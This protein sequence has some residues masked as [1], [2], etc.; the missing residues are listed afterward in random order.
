MAIEITGT[1][2]EELQKQKDELV[3]RKKA[4]EEKLK[5]SPEYTTDQSEDI[6]AKQF[7]AGAEALMPYDPNTAQSWLLRADEIN[8]RKEA[9]NAVYTPYQKQL[10]DAKQQNRIQMDK[11]IASM[12]SNSGKSGSETEYLYWKGQAEQL[13]A[14]DTRLNNLL[15]ESGLSGYSTIGGAGAGNGASAGAGKGT[16]DG[17][18]D[19]STTP[20]YDAGKKIV[21]DA[22]AIDANGFTTK[23]NKLKAKTLLA[24]FKAK[25][26]QTL[27]D[28]QRAS[29]DA[30]I[31]NAKLP[32]VADTRGDAEKSFKQISA[33]APTVI[34]QSDALR[35]RVS[36]I[37]ATLANYTTNPGQSY[38]MG[39]KK[40]LG[41]AIG[42]ADFAGLTSFGVFAGLIA[43]AKEFVNASPVSE[44]QAKR[45]VQGFVNSINS[46]VDTHNKM[47]EQLI[48]NSKVTNKDGIQL[49]RDNYELN[50]VSLPKGGSTE[51]TE[52][53]PAI[54]TQKTY[55][56]TEKVIQVDGTWVRTAGMKF[57]PKTKTWSK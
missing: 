3:A 19:G 23:E 34:K 50:K 45:E 33:V 6:Q 18:G 44:D 32:V 27:N 39:L 54:T 31:D 30:I 20:T 46:A 2:I 25:N 8:A 51:T 12:N 5:K 47:A 15:A 11:A 24:D 42:G 41:D 52:Q 40:Q 43:K 9:R 28:T 14:E 10:V 48:T 1:T 4:I 56:G 55:N 35:T 17:A 37:E 22:L 49:F 7:R 21:D 53:T 16:V 36:G 26:S 57:N 29:L 38:Y 13:K